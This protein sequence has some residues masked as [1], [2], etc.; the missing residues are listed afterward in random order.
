ME[1]ILE[2]S[3]DEEF[4][5]TEKITFAIDKLAIHFVDPSQDLPLLSDNEV[6]LS[7]FNEE[8]W[9]AVIRYFDIHLRKSWRASEG[10]KTVAA[11]FSAGSEV[12]KSYTEI[13]ADR[14]KF[15]E[16]SQSL[17]KHFHTIVKGRDKILAG[18]L[19]FL[20]V[21]HLD[22]EKDF[23]AIYKVE[24]DVKNNIAFQR[25]EDAGKVLLGIV[26]R[27][28]E[29]VLPDPR[30]RVLKWVIAPHPTRKGF[31]LKVRDEVTKNIA[32]YF[33]SF[34]G[35]EAKKTEKEQVVELLKAIPN[36]VEQYYPDL[37]EEI[38][39]KELLDLVEEE[40]FVTTSI[41][42]EK[43]DESG[44]LEDFQKDDLEKVLSDSKIENLSFSTGVLRN[45]QLEYTLSSKIVIKGPVD[46]ME[47]LVQEEEL[48]SG[49][50][51]ISIR[52]DSIEKKYV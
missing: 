21:H 6:D 43:I 31:D 47:S 11:M 49:E 41:I 45:L 18:L 13:K 19:I 3:Y 42:L 52:T 14:S 4:V 17:A 48:E 24:T 46:V 37:D 20:W 51:E 32:A 16:N 44:K 30:D 9:K 8:E 5:E 25:R 10:T 12:K 15:F 26:V 22:D 1:A 28:V 34:L 39:T 27:P 38:T 40:S 23:M 2:E 29:S 33:F 35:C 50:I 36:Y 7:A